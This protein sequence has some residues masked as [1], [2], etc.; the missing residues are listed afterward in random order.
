M[1][2]S[3]LDNEVVKV[4]AKDSTNYGTKMPYRNAYAEYNEIG[5]Q[6]PEIDTLALRW[7]YETLSSSDAGS[8]P[9]YTAGFQVTDMSSG[10]S[11]PFVTYGALDNV[12]K[13]QHPGRG[14]YFLANDTDVLTKEFLSNAKL[15]GLK[16]NLSSLNSCLIEVGIKFSLI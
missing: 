14:N 6:I 5:I 12:L 4:H 8:G 13:K 10:S 11:D 9:G 7:G 1:W 3:Y 15:Q 16:T 2:M